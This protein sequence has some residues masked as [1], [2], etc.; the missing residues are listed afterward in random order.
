MSE[1]HMRVAIIAI[2]KGF[3][4]HQLYPLVSIDILY[5]FQLAQIKF[6]NYLIL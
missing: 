2:K 3:D 1:D 6:Q 5:H 4:V